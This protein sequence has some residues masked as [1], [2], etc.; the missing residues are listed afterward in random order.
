MRISNLEQFS[1]GREL[2]V[3]L[4]YAT[5][6]ECE[7]KIW[8]KIPP[9]HPYKNSCEIYVNRAKKFYSTCALTQ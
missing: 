7:R 5:Y 8:R 9:R 6:F 2:P 1:T 3:H 4:H